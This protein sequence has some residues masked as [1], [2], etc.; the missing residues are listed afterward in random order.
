[1]TEVTEM[2]RAHLEE[3]E[4]EEAEFAQSSTEAPAEA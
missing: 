2:V 4:L 3:G 1:M